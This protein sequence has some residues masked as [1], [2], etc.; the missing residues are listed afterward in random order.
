MGNICRSPAAEAVMKQFVKNEGLNMQ[1]ECDSAGTISYHTGNS[2]DHRMHIAAQNRNITTGGQARQININDYEEFDL[3]LTMDTDNYKN[4][5]SMAPAAKYNAEIKNFC[6]FLTDSTVIEVQ[7]PY[8]GG[9]EGFE[10]VLDLLEDGCF[11][12]IQYARNKIIK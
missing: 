4:V 11:S 1:I 12:L 3:I 9:A 10:E 7:D 8:Y 2:P 5:I 6:D